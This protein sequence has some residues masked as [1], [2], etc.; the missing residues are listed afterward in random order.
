[1][2]AKTLNIQYLSVDYVRR[3]P[4]RQ[5][6]FTDINVYPMPIAYTEISRKGYY[7]R[8]HLFDNR[9]RLKIPEPWG[10]LFW[11]MFDEAMLAFAHNESFSLRI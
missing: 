5:P 7:G 6:F 1:V 2:I 10:R 4:D 8:W 11:D 9:L 3:Y